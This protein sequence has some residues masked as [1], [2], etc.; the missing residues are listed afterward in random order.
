MRVYKINEHAVTV[1]K[2]SLSIND[3]LNERTNCSFTVINPYFEITKGM[4]VTIQEDDEVI[5]SGKV[6]KPKSSG[7]TVKYVSVSC[8]DYSQQIDK[9]IIA[10]AYDN[11]CAGDI[12]RDFIYKY[13][14]DEGITEGNIT[15][16]PTIS[17]A[18]FNYVN[19][20][21]AMN[22]LHEVT[23]YYWE[24]D[25]DKKLN[26]FD[27]TTYTAPFELSDNSF[28]YHLIQAE[29]DASQYRNRQYTRGGYAVSTVQV[30][31]F[32]GDG[33]TQSFTVDLPVAK[34]PVIK[35]NGV[36]KT[37]GIRSLEQGKDWYWSKSDKTISQETMATKLNDSDVLTV[38]YQGFYPIIIVTENS[39]EI[40]NRQATEGGSGIYENVVN[41]QNL[42]S[43]ESAM[44]YT[45]G[46]LEKYGF[47]PKVVTFNTNDHGLKAGQLITIKNTKHNLNGT[48]LIESVTTR[49]DNSLT[50]YSI[51]CLDGSVIGGWEQF[52]KSLVKESK[53]LVIRENEVLVKLLS[54]RDSF[55]APRFED[56]IT[57][58]LHQYNICGQF[59]C[60]VG[61]KI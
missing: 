42:D 43:Q 50:L 35:V 33:E 36:E 16:G 31:T 1:Q 22:Y 49:D 10:E 61:V 20:N 2:R 9:R 37:V 8:T 56:E 26:F 4:V 60:G 13:F 40:N 19:G 55:I 57:Y 3:R 28:N 6:F 30:R 25:K 48:F 53:R 34:V 45:N 5:F 47:I 27:R 23:G 52:F 32:K 59:V 24:I 51:R 15:D 39:G 21:I 58:N 18:V 54:L 46:L 17:R 44:E 14:S 41:E 7:D 11:T 12:V 38:E 29:E